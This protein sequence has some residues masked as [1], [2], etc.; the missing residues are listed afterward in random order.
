MKWHK[1]EIPLQNVL[2]VERQYNQP[3]QLLNQ[4]GPGSVGVRVIGLLLEFLL[5]SSL[6]S[7]SLVG[8]SPHYTQQLSWVG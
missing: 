2:H 1:K 7:D 3:T 8:F 4:V 5:H 6:I